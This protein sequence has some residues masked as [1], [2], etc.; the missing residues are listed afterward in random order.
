MVGPVQHIR[1][2]GR[3]DAGRGPERQVVVWQGITINSIAG[4]GARVGH[5]RAPP[6][7]FGG[8]GV[9]NRLLLMVGL[10]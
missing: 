7:F 3:R 6:N 5:E 10:S 8:L 1:S 2:V 9:Q 4:H